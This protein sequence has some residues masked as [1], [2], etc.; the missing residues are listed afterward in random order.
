MAEVPPFDIEKPLAQIPGESDLAN[1]ALRDYAL[2]GAGRSLRKLWKKY[3]TDRPATAPLPPTQYLATLK[4]WS[5]TLGWQARV[6][7]W[8]L[9]QNQKDEADWEARRSESREQ[10][11]ADAEKLHALF[12]E[13]LD[14]GPSF[15]KRR[16]TPGR[17]RIIED[18]KVVDEGQPTVI[19]VALSI[20]DMV[21]MRE[22]SRK[23]EEGA[24]SEAETEAAQTVINQWFGNINPA[25]IYPQTD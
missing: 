8:T 13:V 4:T 20:T 2:M 18:G 21:K 16:V 9:L 24:L 6:K 14:M 3:T 23:L 5:S 12:V 25:D 22:L 1:A 17:P 19:T 15:L 10:Q 7:A 11:W